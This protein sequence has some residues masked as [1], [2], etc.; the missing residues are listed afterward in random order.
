MNKNEF[1]SSFPGVLKQKKVWYPLAL[2]AFGLLIAILAIM[3]F[4]ELAEEILEKETL[5]FDQTIISAVD[6]IRSDWMLSIMEVITELGAVWWITVVSILT[7]AILWFRKKDLWSIMFFII[8]VAG[9][10][11]LT[12]VLKHF[13]ARSRPTVDAAYDAVGYSFPS[14][15]A[16]GSFILYGFIGYLIIRSQRG[17]TTKWI[18]GILVALFILLIGFSR[19]YLGVHYPSDV[20]AGYAA[21]TLWLF[22][23]IFSLEWVMWIKRSSVSF[24]SFRKLISSKDS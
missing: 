22:V 8:A 17:K 5:Q 9:G 24:S 4:S 3:L 13:F 19:M 1:F 6:V 7:V 16:M 10:G 2:N 23:C 15:H 14:G 12:K 21:G 20:L 11:L 18:S